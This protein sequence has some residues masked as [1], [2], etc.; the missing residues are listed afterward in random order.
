MGRGHLFTMHRRSSE[1]ARD[2]H[3]TSGFTLIELLI[4]V[5]IIGI[6]ATV[7]LPAIR[8]APGKA[9][10]A[11]LKESLFTMRSC[12]DQ[13]L[14]DHGY[15]PASLQELVDTG[16]LRRVPRDPFTKA[17]DTWI[18]I[19]ADAED[20]ED[21]EPLDETGPGI[22]DIQSGAPGFALDGTPYSEW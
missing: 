7:A 20:E 4:V 16:Y 5:A 2:R 22:I 1:A 17:E 9:K 12:I 6:L 15:Y 3:T 10:E 13:Y 21:L 18:E 8:N 19:L 11:V 14:A